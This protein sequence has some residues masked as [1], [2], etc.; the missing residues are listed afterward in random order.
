VQLP[1]DLPL[2]SPDSTHMAAV[3]GAAHTSMWCQ[4]SVR[5]AGCAAVGC[6]Q[7]HLHR[8]CSCTDDMRYGQAQVAEH[9]SRKHA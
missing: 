5:Q 9:H 1:V 3:A 7:L 6:M 2:L 8:C 4:A